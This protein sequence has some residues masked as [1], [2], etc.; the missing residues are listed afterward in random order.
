MNPQFNNLPNP[1]LVDFMIIGAQKCGTTTLADQLA[2]HP[3]ICFCSEKEPCYFDRTVDWR[4]NLDTYHRLYHPQPGQQCGEASTTYTFLPEWPETHQRLYEYNPDLKLIY[5]MRHPVERVISNYAHR[6]V[7][8]SVRTDPA[9]AVFQDP[10][11]VNRSRYGVQ[12]RP[13]LQLF[14]RAQIKLIIFEE[15]FADP[16]AHLSDIANFL[17]IA[18]SHFQRDEAPVRTSN[19]STGEYYLNARLEH[20]KQKPLVKTLRKAVAPSLRTQLRRY[21]GKKLEAKPEFDADLKMML[22]RF[23]EDDVCMVE[24]LLGREL[25]SWRQGY[26]T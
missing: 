16:M 13:Y 26:T 6:L 1:M 21:T 15:Y 4:A 14:G 12:L 24:E 19:K 23:L 9:T 18:D 8:S 22:W 11:Y 10:V 5:I 3:E 25:T 7:R 20:W 2:A 17:G